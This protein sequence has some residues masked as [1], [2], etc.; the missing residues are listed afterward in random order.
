MRAPRDEGDISA[1]LGESA[2][3]IAASANR[4]PCLMFDRNHFMPTSA[5][6]RTAKASRPL[7]RYNNMT[8]QG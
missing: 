2:A 8:S 5:L 6:C 7:R 3:E 4:E 1:P